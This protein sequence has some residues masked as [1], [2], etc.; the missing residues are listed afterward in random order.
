MI[1]EF[2]FSER[3]KAKFF[4]PF[5]VEGFPSLQSFSLRPHIVL[6]QK[7]LYSIIYIIK[8][9]FDELENLMMYQTNVLN[10]F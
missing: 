5:V 2:R 3:R 6:M 10:F 1:A 4:K 8:H 7:Q 9:G